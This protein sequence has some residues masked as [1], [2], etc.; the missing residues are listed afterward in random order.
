MFV[1]NDAGNEIS[2]R[3]YSSASVMS[4]KIF[5]KFSSPSYGHFN[6]TV[7]FDFGCPPRIVRHLGVIVAPEKHLFEKLSSAPT[8]SDEKHNEL[9][10]TQKYKLVSFDKT[11]KGKRSIC[12]EVVII[13]IT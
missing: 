8:T 12:S 7:V 9:T 6:A 4:A 10:W 11:T 1:I 2:L 13:N 5:V 3:N